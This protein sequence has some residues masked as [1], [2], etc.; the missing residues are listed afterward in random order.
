MI[1]HRPKFLMRVR[2]RLRAR[3]GQF[4]ASSRHDTIGFFLFSF[5]DEGPDGV[6]GLI[7]VSS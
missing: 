3:I 7:D 5:R 2:I 1:E 4:D 6:H